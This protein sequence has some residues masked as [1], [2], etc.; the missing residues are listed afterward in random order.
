MQAMSD[1]LKQMQ[2]D[3][4]KKAVEL[5]ESQNMINI[6]EAAAQVLESEK[7]SNE[8]K[9]QENLAKEAEIRANSEKENQEKI[10][11]LE[12]ARASLSEEFN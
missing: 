1:Q 4:D 5:T 2:Q 7:I 10:S 6:L 3:F 12:E 11:E 8:S 9:Y